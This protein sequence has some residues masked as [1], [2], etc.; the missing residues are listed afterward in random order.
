MENNLIQSEEFDNDEFENVNV[1]W[2]PIKKENNSIFVK[3]IDENNNNWSAY[4]VNDKIV[5]PLKE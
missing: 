1:K 3:G 4:L 2:I 5:M